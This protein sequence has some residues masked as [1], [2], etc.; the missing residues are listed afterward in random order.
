[1]RYLRQ[2]KQIGQMI[3]DDPFLA[4]QLQNLAIRIPPIIGGGL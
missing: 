3:S 1:M 4:H 2:G